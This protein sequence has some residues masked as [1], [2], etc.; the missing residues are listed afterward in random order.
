DEW[1]RGPA[2]GQSLAVYLRSGIAPLLTEL[3]ARDPDDSCPTW[4]PADQTYGFWRRRMAHET[5]VHRVDVQGALGPVVDPITEEIALD[6]IDEVLTLWFEHRLAVLNVSA[7]RDYVVAVRTGGRE[8]LV[9][10]GTERTRTFRGWSDPDGP[11]QA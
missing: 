10:A 5:T 1:I 3:A 2:P 8:W 11:T 9:H 4:W 6:G 7:T